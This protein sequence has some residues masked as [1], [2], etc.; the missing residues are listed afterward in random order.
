VVVRKYIKTLKKHLKTLSRKMVIPQGVIHDPIVVNLKEAPL[1]TKQD[2]IVVNLKVVPQVAKQEMKVVNLKVLTNNFIYGF[3]P[4]INLDF[5]ILPD[6]PTGFHKFL[7]GI[8]MLSIV[9]LWCFINII[10]YILT[11]YIIKYTNLEEKYP[12]FKP[13]FTYYQN[14]NYI[15]IIIEIIFFMLTILTV[16]GICI[17]LLYFN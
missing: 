15:F 17:N 11:L 10:G 8:L 4:F 1:V 2:P 6:T 5:S 16:I 9:L 13:L 12:K 3:L 7:L 14:M